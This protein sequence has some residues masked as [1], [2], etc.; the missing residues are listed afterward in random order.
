[1]APKMYKERASQIHAAVP[2]PKTPTAALDHGPATTAIE[3]PLP[4][5]VPESH[6]AMDFQ[7]EAAV[8]SLKAPSLNHPQARNVEVPQPPQAN[9]SQKEPKLHHLDS[10][11]EMSTGQNLIAPATAHTLVTETEDPDNSNVSGGNNKLLLEAVTEILAPAYNMV[12]DATNKIAAT[13]HSPRD[14]SGAKMMWD[15]GVSVKGYLL[16]K[17][18]PG[19]EERALSEVITEVISPRKAGPGEAEEKGVVE[20]VRGAV[21]LLLGKEEQTGARQVH[22]TAE[23]HQRSSRPLFK[24]TQGASI[25]VSG[26]K[27]GSSILASKATCEASISASKDTHEA[28]TVESKHTDGAW[29][30]FSEEGQEVLIRASEYTHE[31]SIPASKGTHG[32]SIHAFQCTHGTSI[33]ASDHIH[34]T[35]ILN[36][37][38][39]PGDSSPL[40]ISTNP[41]FAA[42][43]TN[44]SPISLSANQSLVNDPT[45]TS[46]T[47]QIS[48]NPHAGKYI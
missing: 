25:F 15:K 29:N 32:A 48:T 12:S 30:P 34:A 42:A 22:T 24:D 3:V 10:F 1:M 44:S 38:H 33:P 41:S 27:D 18:E 7:H 47:S 23:P 43:S 28:L 17:L 6:K 2:S 13:I 9:D 20:K 26:Y 37:T 35:S 45:S 36:S 19:E 8:S 31:A 46:T 14:E 39:T 4:P 5:P 21:S 16:Q 40:P 11:K